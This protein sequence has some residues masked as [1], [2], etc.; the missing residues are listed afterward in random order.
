[1]ISKVEI[2]KFNPNRGISSSPVLRFL[3]S[4]GKC[5][6]WSGSVHYFLLR[7]RHRRCCNDRPRQTLR[8]IQS[9]LYSYCYKGHGRP[10]LKLTKNVLPFKRLWFLYL[11]YLNVWHDEIY[12]VISGER[13]NIPWSQTEKGRERREWVGDKRMVLL[14]QSATATTTT[15]M[16]P[17]QWPSQWQW[18]PTHFQ[19]RGRDRNE[20]HCKE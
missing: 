5:L 14:A 16:L 9:N 10:N 13:Q 15:K 19:T 1:M 4:F 2:C 18:P 11:F 3:P 20:G 6:I 12:I 17:P 7:D 8:N